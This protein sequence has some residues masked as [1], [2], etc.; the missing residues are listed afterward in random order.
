MKGFIGL[1]IDVFQKPDH[2]CRRVDG[3]RDHRLFRSLVFIV[4]QARLQKLSRFFR[5]DGRLMNRTCRPVGMQ[6][7]GSLEDFTVL[8]GGIAIFPSGKRG[9]TLFNGW[10]RPFHAGRRNTFGISSTVDADAI[11]PMKH[12]NVAVSPMSIRNSG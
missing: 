5:Y 1:L 7:F 10:P 4:I 12:V 2:S 3:F 9:Q 6:F 11:S 8:P